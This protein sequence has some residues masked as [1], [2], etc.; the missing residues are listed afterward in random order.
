M[1]E[2]LTGHLSSVQLFA[3]MR[4]T[5]QVAAATAFTDIDRHDAAAER[6]MH[7]MSR[8]EETGLMQEISEFLTVTYRG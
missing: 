4:Q 5:A 3:A 7:L 1:S 2:T 6:L 8:A